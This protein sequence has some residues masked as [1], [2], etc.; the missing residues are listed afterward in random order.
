MVLQNSMQRLRQ[1]RQLIEEKLGAS[2][3]GLSPSGYV[4]LQ[5]A[6][7][8][9]I[10]YARENTSFYGPRYSGRQLTWEVVSAEEGADNHRIQLS[11]RPSRHFRGN[12]GVEQIT[13]DKSGPVESRQTISEPVSRTH[14][15]DA[16]YTATAALAIS[17]IAVGVLFAI[18]VLPGGSESPDL[19]TVSPNSGG[20]LAPDDGA[21]VVDVPGRRGRW[22]S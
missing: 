2:D 21:V 19:I 12:P 3:A 4:S 8:L 9:A 5:Q 13:I 11:Y 6:R 16:A 7:E 1:L 22:G 14:L 20:I 10:R 15:W 17:G 18:G